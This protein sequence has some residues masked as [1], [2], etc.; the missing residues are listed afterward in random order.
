MLNTFIESSN[1]LKSWDERDNGYKQQNRL[2]HERAINKYPGKLKEK[3]TT[4]NFITKVIYY[5]SKKFQI[6]LILKVSSP[7]RDSLTEDNQIFCKGLKVG[8]V[9]GLSSAVFTLCSRN[10]C[11]IQSFCFLILSA[12]SF[13]AQTLSWSSTISELLVSDKNSE[14]IVKSGWYLDPNE[15]IRDL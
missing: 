8:C 14:K 7:Q 4:T 15:P 2:K 6:N 13:C 3:H 11:Y 10:S 9:H 5:I 12:S 1:N